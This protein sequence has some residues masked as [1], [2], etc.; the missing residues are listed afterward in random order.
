MKKL[1]PLGLLLLLLTGCGTTSTFKQSSPDGPPR[2]AGYPIPLYDQNTRIPRPVELI[3]EL[4]IGDTQLTMKGGSQQGVLKTLMATARAKGA[5]AVQIVSMKRPDFQ[6]AHYRVVANLYRYTDTWE[7][8]PVS[9]QEFLAYL[10]QHQHTLDPIEGIWSDGS[11]DR[12]CIMKNNSK[13]GRDF[14]AFTLNPVLPSWKL[15]YKKMDIARETRPGGYSI[16]YHRD[17]FGLSKTSV[18]LEKNRAFNFLLHT[19]DQSFEVFY[20]KL[21]P[22]LPAH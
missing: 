11:A 14:V 9:G 12:I 3:G 20:I 6:S 10:Q 19:A 8:V 16:R 15:G 22:P 13:P 5:D 4:S 17:D 18:L 2:P 21:V 1:A 7:T